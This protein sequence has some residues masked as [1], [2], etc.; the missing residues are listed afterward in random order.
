[1]LHPVIL[2]GGIGSRL[3]PLSREHT[4]KQ[5]LPLM[6][7]KTPLQTTIERLEGLPE[8]VAPWILCNEDHRF[9]V[10]EQLRQIQQTTTGII[11][12]PVGRNTAPATAIAALAALDKDPDAILL[13]LPADHL[14]ADIARFQHAV[15]QGLELAQD[16]LVTFGIVPLYPESGYGY[17]RSGKAIEGVESGLQVG[18][19]VEKPDTETAKTYLDSGDYYW[20]S[21]MFIFSA[22][23]YLKTL[24]H[25]EPAILAACEAAYAGESIDLERD[26]IR[27]EETAF[28]SCPSQ[29]IDYAVMEKTES[30]AVI[31][32]DAGWNDIGSW[33]A[34]WDISAQDETGTVCR[35]DVL[36]ESV[37]NSYLRAEY[38]LL[39][40]LGV[41][42]LIVVET[43]DAVLVA[44]KDQA[45]QVK[46]I[47]TRLK[48]TQR[49]EVD[50]HRKVY[51]PWGSYELMDSEPRFQV[52]RIRV[53]PGASLSLQMHHHRSEH[54]V[55][56]AG[57]ANIHRDGEQF[58]LT[59][60]QSTYIP[61]GTRHRLENPGKIPLEII[62]IQSGSYLGEDDIIRFDDEYGR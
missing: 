21:G 59:E 43:A 4:P 22:E 53:N 36:S 61:L 39:A 60:N 15:V 37:S 54:W 45:Q 18:A 33:S 58:L 31:P 8:Q 24:G 57:T 2:S 40:V 46:N 5:L 1:M 34:L 9:L 52:K 7:E 55:V 41:S 13:V 10:A 14:I 29:S 30:A 50:L 6:G 11:L 23:R 62:E 42:D 28:Q 26:F 47:V 38:R 44:H 16:Y 20:N 12:E 17:I 25:F 49:T 56:V 27:L 3:W 48:H 35:G 32:L 19:F 51:R